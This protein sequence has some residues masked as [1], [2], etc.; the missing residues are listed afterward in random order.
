MLGAQHIGHG[1]PG[2]HSVLS[3]QVVGQGHQ[4]RF[5]GFECYRPRLLQQRAG[6]RDFDEGRGD[7]GADAAT[8]G[9]GIAPVSQAAGLDSPILSLC[10]SVA[11]AASSSWPALRIEGAMCKSAAAAVLFRRRLQQ[12]GGIGRCHLSLHQ[13]LR[14]AAR[15]RELSVRLNYQVNKKHQSD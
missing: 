14:I 6:L 9:L 1:A 3:A 2:V 8:L 4:P 10:R 13:A 7:D 5:K 11:Q 12:D 15:R